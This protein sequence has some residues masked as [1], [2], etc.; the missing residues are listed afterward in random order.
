LRAK[1]K[2]LKKGGALRYRGCSLG[3][4]RKPEIPGKREPKRA[5]LESEKV[6]RKGGRRP[7]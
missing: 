7:S 6:G 2:F 4:S 3:G 1:P 5:S